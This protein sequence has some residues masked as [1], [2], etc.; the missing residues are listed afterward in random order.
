MTIPKRLIRTAPDTTTPDMDWLWQTAR[1]LHPSWEHVDLRNSVNPTAFPLTSPYWRDCQTGAQWADLAR[2]EALW[3]RGGVYIDS[4][5]E[6]LKPFDPLLGLDAFA[7]YEDTDH[8]CIAVMGFTPNHPI[9]KTVIELAIQRRH[10]DTWQAGMGAFHDAITG[11]SDITLFPPG[12]FYP[13]S[14]R[15]NEPADWR[16]QNPWSYT[17][18]YWSKSWLLE[19]KAHR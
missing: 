19:Q 1:T 16:T 2:F 4:D 17:A 15:D 5:V 11:R 6:V 9:L 3:W 10:L 13:W 8:V 14:W 12:M 18:H 7:A